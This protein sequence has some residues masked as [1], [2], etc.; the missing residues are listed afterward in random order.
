MHT[1][2]LTLY[3]PAD[4]IVSLYLAAFAVVIVAYVVRFVLDIVDVV[5]P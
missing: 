4:W 2:L 3:T 5:T 1:I